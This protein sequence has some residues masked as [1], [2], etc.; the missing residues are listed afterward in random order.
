MYTVIVVCDA[1]DDDDLN[2]T[3]TDD[4]FDFDV[5]FFITLYSLMMIMHYRNLHSFIG[6]W[7]R[8][9]GKR[10]ILS[11]KRRNYKTALVEYNK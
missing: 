3:G 7:K 2:V 10:K 9:Y 6:K 11:Y 1:A 5:I 8:L 4:D